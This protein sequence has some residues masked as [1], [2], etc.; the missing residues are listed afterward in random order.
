MGLLDQIGG[1]VG[2]ALQ[3]ID[4]ISPGGNLPSQGDLSGALGS[5]GKLFG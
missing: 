4:K 1:A 2:G 3:V 5:L